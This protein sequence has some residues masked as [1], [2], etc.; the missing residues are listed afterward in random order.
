[1]AS[2]TAVVAAS[3]TNLRA[4]TASS[5]REAGAREA[6]AATAGAG[7]VLPWLVQAARRLAGD[8][9]LAADSALAECGWDSLA[10]GELAAQVRSELSVGLPAGE[11]GSATSLRELAS[12][13]AFRFASTR[14][15][16]RAASA[17]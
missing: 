3:H 2:S 8:E 4:N 1:M 6:A 11:V 9:S 12:S 14:P 15:G 16:G 7:E 17:A 13:I 10:R 5:A